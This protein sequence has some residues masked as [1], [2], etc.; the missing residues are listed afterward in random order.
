MIS[1][2]LHRLHAHGVGHI[3]NTW[4]HQG[5]HRMFTLY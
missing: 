3:V 4:L 1:R 2:I 5:A